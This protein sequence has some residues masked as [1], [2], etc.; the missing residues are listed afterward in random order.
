MKQISCSWAVIRTQIVT[1]PKTMFLIHVLHSSLYRVFFF[2]LAGIEMQYLDIQQPSC[3][4]E[5]HSHITS[6]DRSRSKH[7]FIYFPVIGI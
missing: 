3:D 1:S 5:A 4:N 7:F 2:F 6:C